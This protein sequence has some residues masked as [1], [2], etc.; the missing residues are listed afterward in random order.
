MNKGRTVLQKLQ[1]IVSKGNITNFYIRDEIDDSLQVNFPCSNQPKQD[2]HHKIKL[3]RVVN[4]GAEQIE[5]VAE[6]QA[7]QS[8][9]VVHGRSAVEALW[10]QE[11]LE[12]PGGTELGQVSVYTE[13]TQE[14]DLI[15]LFLLWIMC[16]VWRVVGSDLGYYFK[17]KS[18]NL[19]E[20]ALELDR[21]Q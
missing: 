4:S 15:L 8:Q 2:Q 18:N 14:G 10:R 12:V 16:L 13:Q 20:V 6:L 1:N 5:Q 21:N 11:G 9:R 7:A 3:V 17:I 19:I